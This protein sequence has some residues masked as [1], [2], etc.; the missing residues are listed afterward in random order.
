M[1]IKAIIFDLDGTLLDTIE[2]ITNSMNEALIC[3]GLKPHSIEEYKSFVGSGVDILVNKVLS[4]QSAEI[5]LFDVI[6]Q[7][8]LTN[9]LS[10]QND[11]TKPYSGI[12]TLL[13]TLKERNILVCVLSNKPDSDTQLVIQHYFGNYAFF[14]VVGKRKGYE[15]KPHPRSVNEMVQLLNLSTDEILYVGDTGV[16]MQTAV[17]AN[18]TAVGV[19][20]GFRKKDELLQSGAE[21]IISHPSEIIDIIEKRG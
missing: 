1:S 13:D 17:N 16:D 5:A 20:W 4:A 10:K 8:Y 9:Y 6:K 18:L 12:T 19:L 3:Q 15:V 2:D 21:Y 7:Q 11:L 14:Q